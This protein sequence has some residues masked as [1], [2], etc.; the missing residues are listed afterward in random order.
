MVNQQHFSASRRSPPPVAMQ[1]ERVTIQV[2]LGTDGEPAGVQRLTLAPKLERSDFIVLNL[3]VP[4]G[5][6]IEETDGGDIIVEGALPGYSAAGGYDE[7]DLVQPGDLVR[8]VTAY[9]QVLSGAPMWQQLA[10]YTPVGKMEMKRLIFRTEGATFVDVR[11]AIASHREEAGGNGIVT[12]LLE[13]MVNATVP[14][15]TS[16]ESMPPRLEPLFDVIARDL[17][18][19]RVEDELTK[20]VEGM[21]AAERTQRLLEL[22]FDVRDE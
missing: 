15:S 2:D 11:D 5:M 19:K 14:L 18:K 10:S 1:R 21:S 7:P 9:R 16:R 4:L 20:Q 22:G 6:L 13:R 12:L 3:R 17:K 8:A